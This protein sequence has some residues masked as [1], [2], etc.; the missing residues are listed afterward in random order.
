M[1]EKRRVRTNEKKTKGK[2]KEKKTHLRIEVP[3][4]RP[5]KKRSEE[6]RTNE[7]RKQRNIKTRSLTYM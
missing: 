4:C 7:K 6:V 1:N 3:K 5:K 2:K